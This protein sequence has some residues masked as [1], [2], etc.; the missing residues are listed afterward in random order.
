MSSQQMIHHKGTTNHMESYTQ[1]A[2]RSP[3]ATSLTNSSYV[4]WDIY[5][6]TKT[7][8][9]S[10]I[11]IEFKD[12]FVFPTFYSFKGRY[13]GNCIAKEW[14]LYGLVESTDTKELI[15]TLKKMNAFR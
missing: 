6:E 15:A 8:H 14:N 7:T 13:N 2:R 11:E 9:G 5:C 1:Y 4:K 3:S 12:H 10:Y